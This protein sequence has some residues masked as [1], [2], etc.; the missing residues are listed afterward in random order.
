[1][2]KGSKRKIDD[3]INVQ[4]EFINVAIPEPII[5]VLNTPEILFIIL[6]FSKGCGWPMVCKYW[7][8]MK[9][10]FKLCY[11]CHGLVPAN[12]I[13]TERP[14]CIPFCD[15]FTFIYPKIDWA[16]WCVQGRNALALSDYEKAVS[17]I[18]G[19]PP[20]I[21]C[22]IG[23]PLDTKIEFNR[24]FNNIKKYINGNPSPKTEILNEKISI[25]LKTP[26]KFLNG[27]TQ[28]IWVLS[29]LGHQEEATTQEQWMNSNACHHSYT[30]INGNYQWK[31][32]IV[33]K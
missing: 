27:N 4:T 30:F 16:K 29:R 25:K 26:V 3:I 10:Y 7:N 17:T 31:F 18:D 24:L 22:Y 14:Y 6:M 21:L 2:S 12:D 15:S 1:M 9:S 13:S 28:T 19:R 20:F 23:N 5:K 32:L 8:L 33:K 11:C